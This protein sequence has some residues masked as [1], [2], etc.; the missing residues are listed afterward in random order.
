MDKPE[1]LPFHT[2]LWKIASRCNINCT[3]C[4]IYNLADGRWRDQPAFMSEAVA[5]QTALR[6]RE[7]CEAHNKKDIALIFHGGEPLLGGISHLSMLVSVIREILP[8]FKIVMGMQSNG[9]L[10]TEEIGDFFKANKISYG[11]SSDGPPEVNDLHRLD[12]AGKPISKALE[13]KIKL[14]ASRYRSIWAGFLCVINIEAD[15]IA[16]TKYLLSFSPPGFDLILPYYNYG[17]RPPGKENDLDT[18]PYADWLIKCF[19]YWYSQNS[20]TRIRLFNSFIR[21]MFG[22]PS[23]VEAVGLDPVDLIV[24]ET[25]GEIEAVDSL[26]STYDGATKLGFNVFDHQFDD[27][28]SHFAVRSRQLGASALC[29]KCQS[30]P[31]LQVCGGGY[32]PHRYS[33]ENNSFKNPSVY[34]ADLEKIIRHIYSAVSTDLGEFKFSV[35]AARANV[36]ELHEYSTAH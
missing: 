5:R 23:G 24:V 10:F 15:P 32:I 34:C 1:I 8:D 17:M 7:H 22:A 26:K 28:A 35:E 33:P 14:I 16:V 2:Y 27:V 30:C 19:D 18:T 13:E 3:Y 29:E 20:K 9:L 36:K 11:V 31:V 4:Y 21:L 6:M 25:N 12:H